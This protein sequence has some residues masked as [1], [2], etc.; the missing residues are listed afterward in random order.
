MA[1][2]RMWHIEWGLFVCTAGDSKEFVGC[3]KRQAIY[4]SI[5]LAMEHYMGSGL[6][7][8]S[9]SGTLRSH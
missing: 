5:A 4:K 2:K 1:R 7:L 9:F 6:Y 8:A 3:G